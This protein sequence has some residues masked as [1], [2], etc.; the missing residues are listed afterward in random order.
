MP[1]A[2]F[3]AVVLTS[4]GFTQQPKEHLC[5]FGP[6][7]PACSV[8]TKMPQPKTHQPSG[9]GHLRLRSFHHPP[10]AAYLP[11]RDLWRPGRSAAWASG[12]DL[13]QVLMT[14]SQQ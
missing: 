14:A 12:A 13:G 10:A 4:C 11:L 3:A 8:Q 7:V 5:M 1:T 6:Q 9:S 2:I